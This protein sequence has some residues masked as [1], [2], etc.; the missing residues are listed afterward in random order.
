[1]ISHERLLW[2]VVCAE[3]R[4]VII[5]QTSEE[6]RS[7]TEVVLFHTCSFRILENDLFLF[8]SSM[9][10]ILSENIV[11]YRPI[12]AIIGTIIAMMK[13]NSLIRSW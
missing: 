3:L 8:S 1:V 13:E 10:T 7:D 12:A 2:S 5:L 9:H 6:L 4:D 11:G